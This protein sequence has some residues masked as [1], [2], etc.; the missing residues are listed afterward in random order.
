MEVTELRLKTD[1]LEKGV[2]ELL[3]K[4]VEEVGVYDLEVDVNIITESSLL[5]RNKRIV[6][7]K[8]KIKVIV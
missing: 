6:D 7:I 2:Q 4:F 8:V 5:M 1:I 3:N